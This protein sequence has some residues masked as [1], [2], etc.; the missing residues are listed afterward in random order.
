M[1]VVARIEHRYDYFMVVENENLPN[2][3]GS[4]HILAIYA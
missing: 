1:F 3:G 4:E 2:Y